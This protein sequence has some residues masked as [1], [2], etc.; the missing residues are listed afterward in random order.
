[1]SKSVSGITQRNKRSIQEIQRHREDSGGGGSR[2]GGDNDHHNGPEYQPPGRHDSQRAATFGI[3]FVGVVSIF[4]V[5]FLFSVLFAETTVTVYPETADINIDE[6]YTASNANDVDGVPF[7]VVTAKESIAV[8]ATTTGTEY[9]EQAASGEITI[10]NDYSNET[11]RLVP[12]TRFQTDEELIYRTSEAITVPGQMSDGTPG[13][14]IATVTADEPGADYNVSNIRFSIPGFAD[15][16]YEEDVYAESNGDISGGIAG[17]VPIVATSTRQAL[18]E[19][20]GDQLRSQLQTSVEAELP[21]GFILYDDAM[22]FS[23]SLG[24]DDEDDTTL[25]VEGELQAVVFDGRQ[26]STFLATNYSDDISPQSNIRIQNLEDFVFEIIDR[27]SYTP[28]EGSSFEF[29]LQGD[30]QIVW[31][32]DERALVR[33]LRGLQKDRLN[34]VLVNYDSI[35]EAEVVTRPFWKQNLPDDAA[36]IGV[37]TVIDR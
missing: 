19:E 5:F 6:T 26:L 31:Q 35:Q 11:I 30:S 27:E 9:R 36:E 22:F 7:S 1:M 23:T 16:V 25:A 3:W 29:S 2:N 14:V 24:T 4:F 28:S 33:D 10:Y 15:T 20:V 34:E 32:F 8:N 12:N 21:D 37:Q 18:E 17:D 13:T